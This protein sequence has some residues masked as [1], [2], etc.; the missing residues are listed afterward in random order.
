MKIDGTTGIA[1]TDK[2]RLV[3][4]VMFPLIALG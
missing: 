2:I 3:R 4:C 1:G